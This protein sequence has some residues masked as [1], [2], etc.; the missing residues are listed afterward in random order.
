[1][2]LGGLQGNIVTGY[3]TPETLYL[4]ARVRDRA[5]ARRWLDGERL[6]V[7][8]YQGWEEDPSRTTLNLAF[9]YDGLGRMGVPEDRI[10]HLRPFKQGMRTRSER[11]GDVGASSETEWEPAL[12][13]EQDVLLVVTALD[14]ARRDAAEDAVRDRLQ[15]ALEVSHAERGW[16]HHPDDHFG[17]A[18]GFSQ[19]SIAGVPGSGPR[20]GEGTFTRR[21]YWRR[22]A[23]G[24]F[25][26]GYLDEGGGLAPAP[27]GPLGDDATFMVL[28][29]LR[30][31]V[32]AFRSYVERTAGELGRDADWVRAKMVG[33]W[34]NGSALAR[35][36]DAPGPPARQDLK[37]SRFRYGKDKEGLRC[38]R[39]AHVRRAN[40]RDDPRWQGRPT[41]RHRI[42]RRGTSYGEKLAE[43]RLRDDGRDRG[44]IFV[45]YQADIERQF[46]FIQQRWLADGNALRLGSDGDPMS[47]VEGGRGRMV[48]PGRPPVFLT[49]IPDFVRTRGGGY[50]LVPGADGLRALA[51]GAC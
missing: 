34:P 46:E 28:R 12:R 18:D 14:R 19:P 27:H 21:R 40:P 39:G 32:A 26:L 23:L 30:Q 43:G 24:D 15:G 8:T 41:Q 5:G 49:G 48:I 3:R 47:A 36:P 10:A 7:T 11:L 51:A 22:L 42:I 1:M 2:M 37:A 38:P 9:S 29:K 20:R 17:F 33:R 50:Y 35:Y 25:V 13:E 45:S 31:D 4:F 44:L 6:R 16:R